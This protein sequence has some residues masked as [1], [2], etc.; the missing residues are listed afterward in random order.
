MLDRFVGTWDTEVTLTPTGEKAVTTQGT[1]MRKWSVGGKFV[2][3]EN[4]SRDLADSPEFHLTLTYDPASKTYHGV[5]MF[6]PNRMLVTGTWDAANN[7]ITFNGKSADDGGTFVYKNRFVD[8]DHCE[9]TGVMKNGKGEV[10]MEQMQKQTRR[11][12]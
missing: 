8:K 12:K 1:E 9:A 11:E 4:A 3:F 5:M 2:L 6:G 10:F 7:T